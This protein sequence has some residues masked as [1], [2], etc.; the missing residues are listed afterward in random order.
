MIPMFN[1]IR[2]IDLN[3]PNLAVAQIVSYLEGLERQLEQ[4]FMNIGSENL[5]KLDLYDLTL[6]TERGTEISGDRIKI[7]SPTGDYFEI[8]FHR[9]SGQ[10]VFSLPDGCEITVGT[11]NVDTINAGEVTATGNVTASVVSGTEDVV[12]RGVKL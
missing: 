1:G 4:L 3:K 7:V 10:F 5:Q 2:D 12:R 6:Y 9:K 8:G 11:L